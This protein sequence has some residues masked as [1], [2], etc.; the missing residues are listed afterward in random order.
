MSKDN[1]RRL[2]EMMHKV[3]KM[4]LME[5]DRI[6]FSDLRDG[7][8]NLMTVREILNYH[9][10]RQKMTS[11]QKGPLDRT[12]PHV[13]ASNIKIKIPEEGLPP[14][15][16]P[17]GEVIDIEAFKNLITQ[18]PKSLFGINEKMKKTA[19]KYS[20]TYDCG[21]PAYRSLVF[22][23]EKNEFLIVNTCTGAGNCV[24]H[25]Y[26]KSGYYLIFPSSNLNGLQKLNYLLNYPE[27]YEEKLYN[28]IK[29]KIKNEKNRTVYMRWNDSGDF[30]VKEYF[31]I[32]FDITKRLREEG[33][34]NS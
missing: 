20:I 14:E 32:A 29:N 28:D 23:L 33:L 34:I 26:A 12:I 2:F 30:F 17:K 31:R 24:N 4:P 7:C 9:L 11:Y 15:D 10:Q 5:I 13:H 27:K 16:D 21:L 19:T 1:K 25:C 3:G 8:V 18:E 6:K 22:D